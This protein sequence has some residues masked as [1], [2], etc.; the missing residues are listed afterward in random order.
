MELIQVLIIMNK[1]SKLLKVQHLLSKLE[2]QNHIQNK[3][4]DVLFPSWWTPTPKT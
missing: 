4:Y 3:V 1:V 2:G